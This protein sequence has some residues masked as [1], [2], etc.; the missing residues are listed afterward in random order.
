MPRKDDVVDHGIVESGIEV[1]RVEAPDGYG[2]DEIERLVST[3]LD[4]LVPD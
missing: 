2:F 4:A 1:Q 3:Y